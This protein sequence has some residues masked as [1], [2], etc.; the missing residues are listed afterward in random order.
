M[1]H[2]TGRKDLPVVSAHEERGRPQAVD[3]GP[4]DSN[5]IDLCVVG[6]HKAPILHKL[7]QVSRLPSGGGTKIEDDLPWLGIEDF[8]RQHGGQALN[9]VV[10]Q[11]EFESRTGS[12]GPVKAKSLFDRLQQDRGRIPFPP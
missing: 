9:M 11:K 5:P 6:Y 10:A 12:L 1:K 8:C 3:V 2:N 7:G 4:E